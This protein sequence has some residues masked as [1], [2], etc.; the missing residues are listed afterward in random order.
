MAMTREPLSRVMF[1]DADATLPTITNGSRVDP[2]RV[3]HSFRQLLSDLQRDDHERPIW[4]YGEMVDLV[5]EA[6]HHDEALRLEE[7]WNR[8]SAGQGVTTI[9]G[10]ALRSFDQDR[11]ATSFRAIC[12]QHTH[13]ISANGVSDAPDQRAKFEEVALLQQ[14]PGVL[15]RLLG[16]RTPISGGAAVATPTVYV[17]DDDAGVRSALARLL[18]SADFRVHAFASAEAFLADVDPTASGCL[19]LDVHLEGM[20]GLELQRLMSSGTRRSMPIIVIS[21]SADSRSEIEALSLGA[22]A[23]LRKPLDAETLLA[24]IART[25]AGR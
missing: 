17:I 19:I 7:L 16:R 3:E 18:V 14:H 20:N 12:R 10:Y 22:A 11:H 24:A 15:D 4:I 8:V 9:C 21:G 1:I 13:V 23:F 5:S 2:L 6:G 25:G